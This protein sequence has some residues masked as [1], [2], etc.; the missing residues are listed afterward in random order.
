MAE[1][2]K[3]WSEW[4]KNSRFSYMTEVQKEQTLRWLES[5][6]D[7][8]LERA[9]IKS[10]D[11]IIDIGTG[12]GLL[13]FGSYELAGG[14]SRV[15]ASDVAQDCLDECKK[16][17]DACSI[18]ENFEYLLS[19]ADDIKLDDNSVDV[20]VMRSVLVHILDKRTCI[21]EFYRI[22]NPGGRISIFEPVISTNTKYYDLLPVDFPDYERFKAA[23]HE[24]MTS[25]N[26]PLTN[27]THETLVA[28]FEAVGFKNIKLD[29]AVE[30]S[31]YPV[32]ASMVEPWF[33]L[34]PSPNMPTIRDKFLKTFS[35]TEVDSYIEN[36]KTYLD[37]KT[38]TVKSYVAYISAEK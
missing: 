14:S 36:V 34:P 21:K 5:V 30:Q 29:L 16:I 6:K 28:D 27:F 15:I 4:L 10:G 37:G 3:T 38:I 24:M 2:V 13:A 7:K 17:A 12:T 23:E 18:N 31:I 22:L 1:I 20:A 9:A 33:N 35:E 25:M 32:T 8:V 26:D 19:S 11:T